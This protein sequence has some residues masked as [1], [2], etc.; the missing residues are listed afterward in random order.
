[1]VLFITT[2][3]S[4]SLFS[5][6]S[7]TLSPWICFLF[8]LSFS[9]IST[10]HASPLDLSAHVSS[11]ILRRDRFI[12]ENSTGTPQ[13]L[14]PVTNTTVPQG[15][16]TDAGGADFNTPALI[17][18]SFSFIIGVPMSLAGFR[19]WRLSTGVGAGL[20]AAI[21][22]W[23]ALIN[24]IGPVG[25]SDIIISAIVLGF[26]AC[27]FLFGVLEFGRITGTTLLGITGGLAFGIRVMILK[28]NLLLSGSSLFSINW[29]LIAICGA[30]GGVSIMWKNAQRKALLLGCAS[31]GTFL[32][33][34]GVDLVINKQRGMSRGLRFLF[35][36]NASHYLDIIGNGYAPPL[37]TQI[38]IGISLAATSVPH[39]PFIF[40]RKC[41]TS[42]S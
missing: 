17:W 14:N 32:I 13:V 41:S 8:L 40:R 24:S 29:V 11:T 42:C 12:I 33:S 2:R 20:A 5:L 7:L 1:M 35:D 4:S 10:T 18:L 36:R 23:A 16:P 34:L 30:A 37:L 31:I 3:R 38:I 39:I 25:A 21:A 26:F 6:P 22:S 27:G 28:S 15:P 9:C 19:G